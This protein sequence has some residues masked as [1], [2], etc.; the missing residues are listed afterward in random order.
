MNI[1]IFTDTYFPQVSGVAT[2][3]KMLKEELEKQGHQVIVFTTTDPNTSTEE[4]NIVRFSSIPFISFKDRRI[5]IRGAISAY[6]LAKDYQLDIIHTQTEFGVGWLGK[7]VAKRLDIPVIHTNH[8]MYE[9]YLHYIANGRLVKPEHVKRYIQVFTRGMLGVVCPSQRAMEKIKEYEIKLPLK[10]V[11][12]GIRVEKFDYPL[13]KPE[14]QLMKNNLG[15]KETDCVLLSLSRLSYEKN[16]QEIIQGIPEIIAEIPNIKLVIVGDGPYRMELKELVAK[17]SLQEQVVFVGEVENDKVPLYYQ[18]ADYFVSASTSES[19][20]LTYIEALASKT[21]VVAKSNDYLESLFS[22]E[23]LGKLFTDEES[24]AS[25]FKTYYHKKVAVD[26]IAYEEK[27]SEISSENFANEMS[28]FY[29][30]ALKIHA[31]RNELPRKK[32]L[33]NRVTSIKPNMIK[34]RRFISKE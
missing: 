28:L 1:G 25:V 34:F 19:Q 16:I 20:G 14:Q 12:T 27:F 2:S 30:Q 24:F 22:S 15:I 11:P 31:V 6:H 23:K 29:E 5:I 7:Y 33:I 32:N 9:D 3:I 18:L 4:K 13:D 17:Y 21:L 10:I 26:L 8:T